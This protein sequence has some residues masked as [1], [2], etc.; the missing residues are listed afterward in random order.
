MSRKPHIDWVRGIAVLL[1]ILW[2]AID[3]WT[4]LDHRDTAAFVTVAFLGGWAAPLFVFL[5]GV[6]VPLAGG[7]RMRRG[8]S[9]RA[10][11][12]T[13]QKRGWEIFLLAHVFRFQSFL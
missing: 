1:M 5:A 12:W 9:R 11:A 3:S 13:I 10:A 6:S 8:L 4:V 7:A 2:H